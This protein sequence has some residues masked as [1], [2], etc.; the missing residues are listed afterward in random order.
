MA[1]L[2]E[3]TDILWTSRDWESDTDPLCPL[4]ALTPMRRV[5][6]AA[7]D[8]SELLLEVPLG[9][10][11]VSEIA[12]SGSAPEPSVSSVEGVSTGVVVCT[13]GP[14]LHPSQ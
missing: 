10:P 4:P 9:Q 1:K 2:E 12:V 13:H 14:S 7:Q 3:E 11:T 8:I 6:L 5:D